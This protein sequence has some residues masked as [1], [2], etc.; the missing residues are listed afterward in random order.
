MI[1]WQDPNEKQEISKVNEK[2]GDAEN[3]TSTK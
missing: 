1:E 2:R 3:K